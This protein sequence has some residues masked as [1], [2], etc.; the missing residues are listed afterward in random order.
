MRIKID[1]YVRNVVQFPCHFPCRVACSRIRSAVI[2]AF[3]GMIGSSNWIAPSKSQRA[4]VNF[5]Q[6][7]QKVPFAVR[8][9]TGW[10]NVRIA[11]ILRCAFEVL[12]LFL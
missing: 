12:P 11:E 7:L 6:S 1:S 3:A 8:S 4:G 2:R 5:A 10:S 9:K